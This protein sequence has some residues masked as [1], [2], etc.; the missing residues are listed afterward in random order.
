M[1][2]R[3]K[4]RPAVAEILKKLCL[5]IAFFPLEL[6]SMRCCYI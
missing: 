3:F 4:Q 1:S 6:V 2:S 5:S